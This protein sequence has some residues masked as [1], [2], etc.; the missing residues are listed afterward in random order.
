MRTDSFPSHIQSLWADLRLFAL[1]CSEDDSEAEVDVDV[2]V[3]AEPHPD[4][5][6]SSVASAYVP[7]YFDPELTISSFQPQCRR[8]GRARRD[9][10]CLAIGAHARARRESSERLVGRLF[11][12][13]WPRTLLTIPLLHLCFEQFVQGRDRDVA[14]FP[15][16]TVSRPLSFFLRTLR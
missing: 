4:P 1:R 3:P 2:D 15:R 8:R 6:Q 13:Q 14:P 16:R 10:R 12:R 5:L 11:S 9:P 7:V